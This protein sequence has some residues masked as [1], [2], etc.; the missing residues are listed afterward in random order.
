MVVK[1][2]IPL[3]IMCEPFPKVGDTLS[4]TEHGDQCLFVPGCEYVVRRV[5]K[6]EVFMVCQ[7]RE[8]IV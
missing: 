3:V 2:I 8:G 1:Y 7:K 4:A 5:E 6:T